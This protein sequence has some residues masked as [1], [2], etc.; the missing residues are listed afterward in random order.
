MRAQRIATGEA[1]LILGCDLLTSASADAIAKTRPGRTRAIVNAHEQPPGQFARDP[2]W[3]FPTQA[4]RRLLSDAVGGEALFVNATA[5][6]SGLLGDAIGANLFMLGLAWQRGAIP[7]RLASLRR[8]IELNGVAVTMNLAAFTLGRE[9]A[10]DLAAVER[11][12]M[13]ARP[14]FVQKPETLAAMVTRETRELAL[15]LARLPERIRGYGHVKEASVA[16]AR[17][18]RGELLEKIRRVHGVP[19]MASA[20]TMSADRLMQPT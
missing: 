14:A 3:A 9:A 1:D 17:A 10:C 5:I 8:A 16:V 12:A 4:V 7:L 15:L 6:A 19:P 13:P 20:S 2:D 11:R 18:Q